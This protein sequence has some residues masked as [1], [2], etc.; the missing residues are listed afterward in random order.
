VLQQIATNAS[1]RPALRWRVAEDLAEL[2][3]P[4]RDAAVTALRS[5]TADHTLPVTAR[6][7]AARLLAEIR[8]S[9]HSEALTVLRELGDTDNPLRRRQVLLALGALDTTEAVPP[10]RAMAQDR[11][12][13]PVVRLRCAQALAQL[14]RDQR[15]TVSIVARE[16]MRDI[17]VPRHV[18]A[19]AARDLARWSELC[20]EEAHDLLRTLGTNQPQDP[21]GDG[22]RA[23]DAPERAD[24]VSL[25]SAGHRRY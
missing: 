18:R 11:T 7:K 17:T 23:A 2:G 3:V 16:L 15:E 1:T 14:R 5:I 8:P 6:A 25:G 21:G 4:G 22:G 9:S 19:R 20:R 10:L 13:S 24:R 12:L